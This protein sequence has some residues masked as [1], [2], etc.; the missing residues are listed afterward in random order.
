[1]P[2]K[3]DPQAVYLGHPTDYHILVTLSCKATKMWVQ[4]PVQ[5]NLNVIMELCEG[6]WNVAN[7]HNKPSTPASVTLLSYVSFM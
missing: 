5:G 3:Q 7:F 6:N 2:C 1:M 4:I